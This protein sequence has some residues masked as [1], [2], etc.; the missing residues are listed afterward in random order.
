MSLNRK[1]IVILGA[2]YAGLMAALRLSGKT[3]EQ[4]AAIL[5]I[6]GSD[7]LVAQPCQELCRCQPAAFPG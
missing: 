5:L 1:Q 3:G 4:D 7:A 2:G 6:N